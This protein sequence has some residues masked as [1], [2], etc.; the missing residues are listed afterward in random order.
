M[1]TV[2][3]FNYPVGVAADA[4]GNVYVADFGSQKIRKISP[5]G[6]VTTLAGSGAVGDVDGTGTAASFYSPHGIAVDALGN[7]YVAERD[8]NK[9]RKITPAGVVTTLA[10]S[11]F[12]GSTDANGVAATFNQPHGIAV[13]AAGNVYVAD[14]SNQKIRKII[15][16][17]DVTTLAGSGIAGAADGQGTAATFSEPVSIAVD[18]SGNL[19]VA[20][21]S[22]HK[23]RKITASGLVTTLAGSGA[24]GDT[25]GVGA[26]AS[27]SH[28]Y[29]VAVDAIPGYVYVAD[30]LNH[31]IRKIVAF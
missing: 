28:L 21:N 20:D 1:G 19:Y 4:S 17:G 8:N 18:G 15:P 31:K 6:V 24:M 25:D 10:G 23:V 14:R 12:Q 11:G 26:A 22:N 3:S 13:D 30:R 16:N 2:A 27:F 7:V 5:A 9:I 29:G